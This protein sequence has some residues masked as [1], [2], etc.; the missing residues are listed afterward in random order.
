MI[1]QFLSNINESAT[2]LI[3]QKIFGSKQA[4]NIGN[5]N[6]KSTGGHG[7]INQTRESCL[8]LQAKNTGSFVVLEFFV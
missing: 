8:T 5:S 6:P 1:G 7:R 4:Y 3:L 2:I